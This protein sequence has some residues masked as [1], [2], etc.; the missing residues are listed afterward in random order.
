MKLLLSFLVMAC[1]L[2][3]APA[4]ATPEVGKPAPDFKALDIEGHEIALSAL[5]GKTIVLEWTNH[6]CPFVKKHYESG[7]MQALQK[8]ATDN[9]VIWVSIVSSAEGKE[10]HIDAAKAKALKEEQGANFTHKILDASGELGRKYDAKTTPHMFVI[11]QD[12]VLVYAGAIDDNKSAQQD[13]I[14]TSKN[15][16][17]EALNALKEGKKPETASTEPYGCSVKY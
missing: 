5:Q 11:D 7:N 3:A 12:G 16:V 10:G 8:E 13:V 6:G 1:A 15:Y 14:P 17:R 2:V 9:G 4:F